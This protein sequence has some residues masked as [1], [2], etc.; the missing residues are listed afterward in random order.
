MKER[1]RKVGQFS[2]FRKLKIVKLRI[3][4]DQELDA[5]LIESCTHRLARAREKQ[6]EDERGDC[7][8]PNPS[9]W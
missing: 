6:S 9:S 5:V 3:S 2:E 4:F 1:E 7:I 8:K